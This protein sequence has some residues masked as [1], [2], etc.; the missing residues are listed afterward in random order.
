MSIDGIYQ[1]IVP[2]YIYMLQMFQSINTDTSYHAS[3]DYIS[4]IF[5][6]NIDS[7]DCLI[8]VDS[9]TTPT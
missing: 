6:Y 1:V 3:S 9:R 5:Q 8:L 4:Y 2:I 7:L